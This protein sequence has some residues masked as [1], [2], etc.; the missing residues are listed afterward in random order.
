M[1]PISTK[2]VACKPGAAEH[3]VDRAARRCSSCD[4][5]ID[6]LICPR[7]EPVYSHNVEI[8]DSVVHRRWICRVCLREGV[9]PMPDAADYQILRAKKLAPERPGGPLTDSPHPDLAVE[10]PLSK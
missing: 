4:R 10:Y 9:E 2:Y 6:E 7:C 5:S 8:I 3:A 1:I